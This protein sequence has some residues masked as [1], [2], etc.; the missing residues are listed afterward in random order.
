MITLFE[1]TPD[2]ELTT[3]HVESIVETER[4]DPAYNIVRPVQV[5]T[6]VTHRVPLADVK[7][8]YKLLNQTMPS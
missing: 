5:Y 3:V 4:F 2:G 1:D 8:Q 6:T 7:R